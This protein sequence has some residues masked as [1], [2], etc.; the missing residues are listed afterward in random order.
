MMDLIDLTG[1]LS[2]GEVKTVVDDYMLYYNNERYQW[3]L[4]QRIFLLC[5][6]WHLSL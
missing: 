6:Y 2:Y 3:D 4:S 1:D 5:N